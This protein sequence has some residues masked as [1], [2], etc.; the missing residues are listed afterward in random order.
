MA[1]T[2]S[3]LNRILI[4]PDVRRKRVVISAELA[5]GQTLAAS[6]PDA[7]EG[8]LEQSGDLRLEFPEFDTWTPEQPALYDLRCEIRDA[9]GVVESGAIAF[10]MRELSTKDSRIT[11]NQRG[12]YLHGAAL[13]AA[14]NAGA[15]LRKLRETGFNAVR[16]EQSPGIDLV[17]AEA[18]TLGQFVLLEL[19]IGDDAA[20]E[21]SLRNHPSLAAWVLRTNDPQHA[22]A[23]R[24]F[25]PTRLI[26]VEGLLGGSS[27]L[28]PYCD[29]VEPF[30][31]LVLRPDAPLSSRGEGFMA[32]VGQAA[33]TSLVMKLGSKNDSLPRDE[34]AADLAVPV[35]WDM[36]D[37][38]RSNG[39][40][41][42]YFLD[43]RAEIIGDP[44]TPPSRSAIQCGICPVLHLSRRNLI[45]REEVPVTVT[46]VNEER[47]EGRA[48]LSLQVVGP[49][50]QV[51]WKKKRGVKI[52]KSGKELWTGS[53]AASGS[54][55]PHR[56]VVRLM[57]GMT[58]LAENSAEFHVFEP[59]SPWDAGLQVLDAD[60][61]RKAACLALATEGGA[62]ASVHVVP[63]QANTIRG[64]PAEELARIMGLA[65][66]GAVVIFFEPPE[67]WNDLAAIIDPEM[68]AT[69]V[70]DS[71]KDGQ[72]YHLARLHPVFDGLP[73]GTLL[74]GP[75][76]DVLPAKAFAE[77]GE[78]DI[79]A[80]VSGTDGSVKGTDVLVHRYGGG[81]VVFTHLRLL[82]RLGS[83]PVADRLFVNM[84]RHFSR[85]SVHTGEAF[86]VHQ[87]MVEWLRTERTET[88]RRWMTI[89]PF[90]NWD[91]GGHATSYPPEETIDFQ[92]TYAGWFSPVSWR[93][94]FSREEEGH[95]VDLQAAMA[96]PNSGE[97]ASETGTSY[98]YAECISEDRCEGRL[99][100]GGEGAFKVWLN[101][102]EVL[103]REDAASEQMT[104]EADIF[105]KQGG[106]T[107]LVKQS[108]R[109]AAL[110]FRVEIRGAGDAPEPRWW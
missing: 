12:Y 54:T 42:G 107:V 82:D 44:V 62:Q 58:R 69:V 101:G 10:G 30:E 66:E 17:L 85:R 29:T 56:F 60:S 34:G 15:R 64:Y 35:A 28:R 31:C 65:K 20:L 24:A 77:S 83:D 11:L 14:D 78:E 38:V 99:V 71:G 2:H 13:E 105:L 93:A 80:C 91:G 22:K 90:A 68:T 47:R 63:P 6:L 18:D 110:G 59:V 75:Y 37:A 89:G 40:L 21:P 76:R 74:G 36:V 106:N 41:S 92:A 57:D 16:L 33:V 67:D 55:G 104:A 102:K 72:P 86:P 88:M 53:V 109:D 100:I 48:E 7:V 79:C 81:R 108:T 52:P 45:P 97:L 73:A 49:T 19:A 39:K 96:T 5:E 87:K 51:L 25:D 4:Q 9:N 27:H 43:A 98:A 32:R 94:W 23:V 84:L 46:L 1:D 8:T 50:G 70:E 95:T 26:I 103:A 61:E 3:I